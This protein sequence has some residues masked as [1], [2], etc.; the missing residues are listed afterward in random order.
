MNEEPETIYQTADREAIEELDILLDNVEVISA[1]HI[2]EDILCV[3]MRADIPYYCETRIKEPDK[4]SELAWMTM[5]E[6]IKRIDFSRA[7]QD[8]WIPI[9][10]W[11][12]WYSRIFK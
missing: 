6:V 5:P 3:W 2:H 10:D 12:S 11:L 4:C 7:E 9:N 8:K 1:S